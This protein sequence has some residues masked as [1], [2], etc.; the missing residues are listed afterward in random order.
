MQAPATGTD[1]LYELDKSSQE[2]VT[3]ILDWQKDHVGEG[4]AELDLADGMISLPASPV[5]LPQLQRIRR[6]F[7]SMNRLHNLPKS[8]IRALFVEYLNDNLR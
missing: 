5:S 2:I 1:Y 4:G 8:R 3:S 7:I 6:Q